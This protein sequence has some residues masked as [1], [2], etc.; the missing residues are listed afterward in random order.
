MIGTEL[1]NFR[2][3]DQLGEGGMGVVYK[4]IDTSLDRIVAIKVLS[5]DLSRNPD[6]VERF[7][8]EARAQANLN[9]TNIATLYAFVAQ[10]GQ[11]WMFMEYIKGEASTQMLERRGLLPPD[12]GVHLFTQALLGIGW[13]HRMGI[14]H[15]DIKPSNLMVNKQGIVKVMDFGIAKVLGGGRGLTRTGT[16]LG[17]AYY[18]SPEQVMNQSIDIRSDIYS[19]GVTLYEMLTANL[20]FQ[21]ESDF[22]IMTAHVN[23]PPPSPT[24]HYPYIP[25][26]IENAILKAL[27]KEPA[28]RFQTVEEFGAALEHPDD[29]GISW[30][31][32]PPGPVVPS[33]QPP[34][35]QPPPPPSGAP[36]APSPPAGQQRFS[37][38]SPTAPLTAPTQALGGTSPGATTPAGP[39]PPGPMPPGPMPPGPMPPMPPRPVPPG[40]MPPGMSGSTPPPIPPPLPPPPSSGGMVGKLVGAG[41]AVALIAGLLIWHPWKKPDDNHNQH[42]GSGDVVVHNDDKKETHEVQVWPPPG[43]NTDQPSELKIVEFASD[44][45]RVQAGQTARLHW[46]VQG[47]THIT[48]TPDVGDVDATGSKEIP[49]QRTTRYVL[50]ATK[51][52]GEEVPQTVTVEVGPGQAPPARRLEVIFDAQPDSIA[53]GQ[54]VQLRWSVPAAD[55]V[56]ITP[57]I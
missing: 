51:F 15:R 52:S 24:R 20:P 46:S 17:T 8:A 37:Q 49:V 48:I 33:P 5:P 6:L 31:V 13:A 14:V 12:V 53:P 56:I 26:G 7:R 43:G 25:K 57:G 1:L 35:I 29:F 4:G 50:Q 10:A 40:A 39:M 30:G 41:A 54:N 9:H 19:L 45:K 18:M 55:Q 16:A 27:A 42:N 36:F 21:G 2:I 22:Q 44:A 32:A 28:Q 47:A 34:P 38:S 3:L 11:A 23:V